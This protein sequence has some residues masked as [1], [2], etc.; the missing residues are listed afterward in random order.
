MTIRQRILSAKERG[1]SIRGLSELSNVDVNTLYNIVSG[2]VKN[3]PLE[4][5]N[6]L[7]TALESLEAIFNA[8]NT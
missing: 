1:F 3:I 7:A 4:V 5:E 8:K 6:S 2:R